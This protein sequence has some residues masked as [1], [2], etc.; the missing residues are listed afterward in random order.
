MSASG[1]VTTPGPALLEV[2]RPLGRL[3][4][5]RAP[6]EVALTWATIALAIALYLAYP[7]PWMFVLAFLVVGSRQYALLILMHDAFHSLVHRNGLVN[8]FVG[9]VLIGAPCGSAYWHARAAHLKHHRRLGKDDDP[10]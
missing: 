6:L 4:A 7:T 8:D 5:V 10:E 1:A 2:V 9:A 3:S